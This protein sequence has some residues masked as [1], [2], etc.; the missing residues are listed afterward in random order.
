M[1]EELKTR[2]P[3]PFS[4]PHYFCMIYQPEL[5]CLH[6]HYKN[7]RA[8]SLIP[9]FHE[10]E[11]PL[12]MSLFPVYLSLL[13]GVNLL[14]VNVILFQKIFHQSNGLVSRYFSPVRQLRKLN[15][16]IHVFSFLPLLFLMLNHNC[17]LNSFYKI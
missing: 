1:K 4:V 2:D 3:N 12:S 7:G 5:A 9:A 15:I 11:S 8:S 10:I 13:I 6:L 14:S 16:Q 17:F